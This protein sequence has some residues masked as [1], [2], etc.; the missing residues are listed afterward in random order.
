MTNDPSTITVDQHQIK[1]NMGMTAL[2]ICTAWLF[3]SWMPSAIA[4][5]CMILSAANF[6]LSPYM[7]IYRGLMVPVRLIQPR[8]IP[9]DPMPH[10]FA[11][12]IG[13]IITGI[14][15]ILIWLKLYLIGWVFL[16][17]VFTLQSINLLVNFCT[18]YYM[19]YVFSKIGV[20]GFNKPQAS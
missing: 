3:N 14:G 6:V 10:R 16:G 5:L 19:Y 20:P 1:F 12:L 15:S 9:D 11:A 4:S 8:I 13:A 2:L 18:M 7:L 17:M